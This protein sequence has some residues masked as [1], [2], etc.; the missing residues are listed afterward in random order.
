MSS[1][2]KW[3]FIPLA[4][5]AAAVGPVYRAIRA[6]H[7]VVSNSSSKAI[8]PAKPMP[9]MAVLHESTADKQHEFV[10]LSEELKKTPKHTPVLLRMAQLAREL[11]RLPEAVQH[12]REA[13]ASEP[14]NAEAHL[15]LGRAL[16]E[17]ADIEGAILETKRVLE[18]DTKHVDALY[19]LGAIYGNMN[20]DD[21][22]RAYWEK[23]VAAD[24]DSPSG[25]QA[26]EALPRL[27]SAGKAD[28]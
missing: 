16:F 2:L 28:Y 22:A 4:I 23:A 24:P 25:R 14:R 19:N 8:Q 26:K 27:S 13:V 5:V 9:A 20:R 7:S 12:L 11:G 10:A 17:S 18:I 6:S 21:L 15:E 3:W 1:I